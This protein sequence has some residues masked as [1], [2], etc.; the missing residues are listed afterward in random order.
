M[1][2]GTLLGERQVEARIRRLK[3]QVWERSG[4]VL[5]QRW[6]LV[7]SIRFPSTEGQEGIRASEEGG[8]QDLEGG[9][10]LLCLLRR[11]IFS[12]LLTLDLRPSP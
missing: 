5:R 10:G 8:T 4:T 3:L 2:P 6:A 7:G 1:C 12:F 11:F 9:Q